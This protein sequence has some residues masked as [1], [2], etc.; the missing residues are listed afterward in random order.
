MWQLIQLVFV[1]I[2]VSSIMQSAAPP[3]ANTR[4]LAPDSLFAQVTVIAPQV[5]AG[6]Q[7]QLQVVL[8][9]ASKSVIIFKVAVDYANGTHQ[10]VVEATDGNHTTI[11]FALPSDAGVG[12]ATFRIE[13]TGCGCGELSTTRKFDAANGWFVVQP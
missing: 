7:Q 6:D 11:A 4:T 1:S 3:M 8:N 9:K 5:R 10:A 12:R 2:F 13:T